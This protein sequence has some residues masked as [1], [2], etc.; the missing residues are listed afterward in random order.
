M[1]K[2]K[3]EKKKKVLSEFEKDLEIKKQE[4]P[5]ERYPPKM[6]ISGV[7]Y[8]REDEAVKY[9]NSMPEEVTE[10]FL[11]RKPVKRIWNPLSWFSK[12]EEYKPR[13]NMLLLMDNEGNLRIWDKVQSGVFKVNERHKDS[14]NKEPQH[15]I[16]KPSKLRT[17]TYENDEGREEYDKCW[18]ADIN[19]ANALPEEPSYDADAVSEVVNKAVS[20]NK[21]FAQVGGN[22]G[23][24]WLVWLFWGLVGAYLIYIV[25]SKNLFGVGDFFGV[26]QSVVVGASNNLTNPGGPVD[27]AGGTI[28]G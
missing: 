10:R 7:N 1:V 17:I 14:Q 5:E 3:T 11:I 9:A 19:N 12:E 28:S 16:L 21:A 20:G 2:K 25:V 23:W 6:L 8:I 4:N 13:G 24:G 27:V 26:G 18:V 22:F 15:L